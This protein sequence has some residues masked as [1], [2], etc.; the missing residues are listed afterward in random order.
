MVEELEIVGCSSPLSWVMMSTQNTHH[1][2]AF[3]HVFNLFH[4]IIS[5]F[6]FIYLI[7]GFFFTF[8]VKTTAFGSGVEI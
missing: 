3:D 8:Q 4:L 5:V 7:L 6:I 2:P 1:I